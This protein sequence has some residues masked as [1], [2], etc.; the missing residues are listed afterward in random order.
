M[1]DEMAFAEIRA[2][3]DELQKADARQSEQTK[4]LFAA[5]V[6]LQK[7]DATQSEQIKTLFHTTEKQGAF[8]LSITKLLAAT[9]V[10]ILVIAVLALVFGALGERGFHAVTTAAPTALSVT[11]QEAR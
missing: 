3:I 8:M 9:V 2:A 1:C 11:Q 7:A 4:T 6:E 5:I 10:G